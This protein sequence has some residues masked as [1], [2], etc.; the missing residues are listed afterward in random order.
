MANLFGIKIINGLVLDGT[1]SPAKKID[2]GIIGDKIDAL[3]N[4]SPAETKVT[5]DAA[6]RIVCPG[7]IDA[8][9]HS[10]AYLLIEPSA[11]SKIYQGI[12]T[13]IVG[14]CGAS[15]APIMGDYN[16]PSDWK[17]KE[18]PGKWSSVAEYRELLEQQQPAVNVVLMIGHN[19]L[20]AS[21]VGYDNRQLT[22]AELQKMTRLFE[23]CLDQGGRGLSTGLI[24]P[25]GM[26]A[27][28]EEL[29]ELAKI[30]ARYSGIYATHMRSESKHLLDAIK[31]AIFIGKTANI[32]VEISHLKT[33]GS[34]NWGLI[35]QVLDIIRNARAEGVDIAA[36]R[37]P[38][39]SACTDLDVIFPDWAEEGG[40]DAA[41]K[42]LK[43]ASDRARLRSDLLK[44]R[45]EDY[46][47]TITIGS[48][49]CPDNKKFQGMPFL[50]AAESL[51]MEPVDAILYFT[52]S[53]EL[54]TSAFFFG[55]S[56]KNMMKILAEPY[57]MIGSDASLR[58]LTGQLS[59]DY[60]HPRAYGTF[61]RFIRMAID[62]KTVPLQEAVR[63]ITCLPAQQFHL[64]DRGVIAK[65][66]KA[67]IIVFNP[68]TIQ[69]TASYSNP[70][71][72]AKGIDHVIVNGVQT[73]AD[74]NFTGTR[75]GRFL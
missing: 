17:G 34:S 9:S 28:Q 29:V 5:I 6:E 11:P 41:M 70:H 14:N 27:P 13:E 57:V 1:G 73:L 39:T 42:R 35:D 36:D 21:V 23:Q 60:P 74:G 20:R 64:A 56:E 49:S 61:P 52:E 63:K 24:Y 71:Q 72:F 7:F 59:H 40:R 53:D 10:D 62:K 19:N 12:T 4:L 47:A 8:H 22:D 43:N 25:P 66:M 2:I 46:W 3:G 67:D 48:T 38:Y 45:S 44:S 75:A 16:M 15:A 37:Y 69:D 31:E 33:S 18:Y 68:E 65:G 26:F 32:R 54:K 51:G 50:E 55:M 58:S 30:S